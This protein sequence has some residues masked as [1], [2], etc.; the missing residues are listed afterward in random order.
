MNKPHDDNEEA[1]D[2][3]PS[4]SQLKRESQQLVK[5]GDAIIQLKPDEIQSLDLPDELAEAITVARK[6]KSNSGLKRQRLYI[7]KL[8]RNTDHEAIEARLN[9]I[10]HR[11]DTNTAAF[12]RLEA[13]RDRLIDGD[14]QV[15]GEIINACN[16]VDR[17]HIH[18]LTRHAQQELS[19]GKPPASARKLFRYL[20]QLQDDTQ[21]I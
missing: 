15:L 10:I 13:W 7:G 17:Q 11:H 3:L 5:I 19:Q 8:L 2:E 16:T 18:Q 9:K 20:Q 12:K 4:K 14:K 6:I 1:L 21:S